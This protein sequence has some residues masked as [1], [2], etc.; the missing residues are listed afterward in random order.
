MRDG[1]V[2]P[3]STEIKV[4]A[5]PGRSVNRQA[6]VLQRFFFTADSFRAFKP[7]CDSLATSLG[8]QLKALGSGPSGDFQ[9]THIQRPTLKAL[10]QIGVTNQYN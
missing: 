7:R 10:M 5:M 1:F 6:S 9:P 3:P 8:L 4:S 2:W